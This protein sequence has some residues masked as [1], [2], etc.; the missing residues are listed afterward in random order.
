[1]DTLWVGGETGME[2]ALVTRQGI[3]FQSIPAAGVYGVR[4]RFHARA[5]PDCGAW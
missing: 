2:E 5:G 3:A 1:V 4:Q